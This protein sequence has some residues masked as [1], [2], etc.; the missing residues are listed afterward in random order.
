[1]DLSS[2]CSPSVLS[3]P[4]PPSAAADSKN[5]SPLPS[6]HEL[7]DI[8]ASLTSESAATAT[9]TL[10]VAHANAVASSMAAMPP[11]TCTPRYL[12]IGATTTHPGGIQPYAV[13]PLLSPPHSAETTKP[14]YAS[15][16][17]P[18]FSKHAGGSSKSEKR[19]QSPQRSLLEKYRMELRAVAEKCK[20]LSQFADQYGPDKNKFN[21]QPSDDLV[22]DMA[23]K[24]Y[25]VLMVFMTIRRERMSTNTEDDTMEYIR[26]RRTVLSPTR[27]KARKRSVNYAKLN[28]R[29]AGEAGRHSAGSSGSVA[30]AD[31]PL[32]SAPHSAAAPHHVDHVAAS[33]P[34]ALIIPPHHHHHQLQHVLSPP[35]SQS[36]S[37]SQMQQQLPSS[38]HVST[39]HYSTPNTATYLHP[40]QTP[41][42]P[43]SASWHTQQQQQQQ[44]GGY[45]QR[46][47]QH[48]PI[49]RDQRESHFSEYHQHHRHSPMQVSSPS[50]THGAHSSQQQQQLQRPQRPVP[51]SSISKILG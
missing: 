9:A 47:S 51:S 14:L 1:M 7:E 28:K 45:Y 38:A 33:V 24:A 39:A 20:V 12:Q 4:P 3:P 22:I 8:R 43:R 18:E 37:Y 46:H 16:R 11:A 44:P 49:F 36:A 10:A 26:K 35:M 31:L 2:V 30:P 29:R 5:T 50:Y 23:R 21:A 40:P 42:M 6:V 32:E 19:Q 25:E 17:R 48:Q 41:A 34:A 27:V 13:K 15:E